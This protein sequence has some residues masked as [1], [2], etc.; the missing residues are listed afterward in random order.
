MK[1]IILTVTLALVSQSLVF[2]QRIDTIYYN[3]KD[4]VV[5]ENK[6]KY[7]RLARQDSDRIRVFDYSK[8]GRIKMSGAY[9]TS[10]FSEEIGPFYYYS[11]NRITQLEIHQ[12]SQYPDIYLKY[13]NFLANIP[14]QPDS[15]KLMVTY[16][17]NNSVRSIGYVS[18][19]CL[20]TGPWYFFTKKGEPS[21][22]LT[23]EYNNLNGLYIMFYD[24]VPFIKGEYRNNR[25]DGEWLYYYLD[26]KVRK[27]IL[28][29]DGKVI[30]TIR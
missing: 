17:K 16:H 8:H 18:D 7:Y 21:Y 3:G 25:K 20:F 4:E 23:Y 10:D 30:K 5:T 29:Q 15:L 14:Q 27:T 13:R 2:S 24:D 28:Y 26:G 22:M 19:C 1:E 9:K 12:P 6:Y 11:R